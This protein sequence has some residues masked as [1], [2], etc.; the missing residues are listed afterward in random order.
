MAG[1]CEKAATELVNALFKEMPDASIKSYMETKL[2]EK[3]V[4][5]FKSMKED[6][7]MEVVPKLN[8]VQEDMKAIIAKKGK[9]NVNYGVAMLMYYAAACNVGKDEINSFLVSYGKGGKELL[10]KYLSASGNAAL[11]EKKTV[12]AMEVALSLEEA[13][14][15]TT[16]R[17][18]STELY[19]FAEKGKKGAETEGTDVLYHKVA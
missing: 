10:A 5:Q 16:F 13:V 2:N 12:S 18:F 6:F 11:I 4:A 8:D 14:S 7:L 19:K 17:A 1:P 9:E 15:E 3:F